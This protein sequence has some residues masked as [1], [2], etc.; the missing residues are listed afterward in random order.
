MVLATLAMGVLNVPTPARAMGSRLKDLVM[1]AGARDNQLVG[2]GIVVGLAGEG[3][4]NPS[5]TLQSF[6]NLL[7]RFGVQVP[8]KSLVAKNVAV[9]MIT[10]DI[11]AFAKKAWTPEGAA[12]GY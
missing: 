11:K 3:D 4:K 5:Y 1:I 6:A 7:Q 8:A 10:A 9:V 2:Y 12:S